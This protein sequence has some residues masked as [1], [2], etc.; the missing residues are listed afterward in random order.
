MSKNNKILVIAPHPDDEV[1]GCGGTI[2]KYTDEGK[3]VYLCIVTRNF[4]PEWTDELQRAREEEV[5]NVRKILGIKKV[6]F[7]NL[8]NTKLDT[9]PQK[10]INDSILKCLK[11]VRA[12]VLFVPYNGDV[13]KDHRLIFE[14]CMVAARPKVGY[15]VKKILC[16]EVISETDWAFHYFK[17]T[18]SPNVYINVSKTLDDKI[19][20]MSCYKMELYKEYYSFTTDDI[21]A[22][23]KKRGFDAGIELAESFVLLRDIED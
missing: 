20:A 23:A 8:P 14:A 1:L 5:E 6:F 11:E 22:L 12:D 19:R 21:R 15:T 16:Y 9:V 13:H 7:L 3:E 10:D 18:F 4:G 17:D 2:K